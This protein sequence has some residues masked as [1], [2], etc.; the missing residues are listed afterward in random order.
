MEIESQ[1]LSLSLPKRRAIT[2]VKHS[3]SPTRTRRQSIHHTTYSEISRLYSATPRGPKVRKTLSD[4]RANMSQ[5]ANPKYPGS[6]VRRLTLKSA[7]HGEKSRR[8][9]RVGSESAKYGNKGES[10]LL[11]I[12]KAMPD[13]QLSIWDT[14]AMSKQFFVGDVISQKIEDERKR[15]I[16]IQ[17]AGV[18]RNTRICSPGSPTFRRNSVMKC[19]ENVT[20]EQE[21]S[22]DTELSETESLEEP[23]GFYNFEGYRLRSAAPYL[24][25]YKQENEEESEEEEEQPIVEHNL[26]RRVETALV[27]LIPVLKHQISFPECFILQGKG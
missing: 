16:R 1:K 17:S 11:R 27:S 15:R 12:D 25:S 18:I 13:E 10:I 3:N 2:A 9:L 8:S 24:W 23:E 21:S 7:P 14:R 19:E 22:S 4:L 26:P 6:R 5:S 20:P